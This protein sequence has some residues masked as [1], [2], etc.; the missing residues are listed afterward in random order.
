MFPEISCE[1]IKKYSIYFLIRKENGKKG[2]GWRGTHRSNV[3]VVLRASSTG[4]RASIMLE[5]ILTPNE[6]SCFE[7]VLVL[8]LMQPQLLNC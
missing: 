3:A 2:E 4:W 6:G 8:N 5:D 7:V 1:T